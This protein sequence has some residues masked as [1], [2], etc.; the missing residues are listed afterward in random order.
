MF[1][2][3]NLPWKKLP[4]GD[5]QFGGAVIAPPTVGGENKNRTALFGNSIG[6]D[7]YMPVWSQVTAGPWQPSTGV[8]LNA[9]VHPASI[10]LRAGVPTWSY[11]CTTAGTSGATEPVWPL[12][13]G[14]TVIDGS[15]VW[16]AVDDGAQI[17]QRPG[18]WNFAQALS[19]QKFDEVFMAGATG[20]ASSVILSYR[21][22][23][24]LAGPNIMA[25][26]HMFENDVI[27]TATMA[28]LIEDV[29]AFEAVVKDDLKNGR[30]VIVGTCLPR[31]L[32]D[33]SSAFTGYVSGV[34]TQMWHY[35]NARVRAI[36]R[37]QGVYLADISEAYIDPNWA[38]PVYPDN[39]TTFAL[40]SGGTVNYTSDGT[41]PRVPGHWAIAK[42]LAKT[43]EEIPC[44]K[45][46]FAPSGVG[47]MLALNPYHYGTGGS[48][49][50]VAGTIADKRAWYC[51]IAGATASTVARTDG[52]NGK[53]QRVVGSF[54]ASSTLS[55]IQS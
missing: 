32:I 18:G 35:V 45:F 36:A 17:F 4:S 48:G 7:S 43:L 44:P 21:E 16:T 12:V 20:Q 55:C 39:V 2:G 25:Y 3:I 10:D 34:Q 46:G 30:R 11:K 41:H 14:G 5:V 29:D 42:I 51:A 47:E 49:T 9:I 33:S 8:V 26:L 1:L 24:L 19:G 54:A 31:A 13:T 38:R 27:F 28:E 50:N 52:V 22:K 6:V 40:G 15:I 53:W 23:A 37:L